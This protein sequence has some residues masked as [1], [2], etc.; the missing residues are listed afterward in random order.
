MEW[1]DCTRRCTCCTHTPYC[2][3]GIRSASRDEVGVSARLHCGSHP[4][5]VTVV[6]PQAACGRSFEVL[7]YRTSCA[8]TSHVVRITGRRQ[9]AAS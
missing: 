9:A 5:P 7:Q 2:V 6:W 4:V 8:V 1:V 3:A